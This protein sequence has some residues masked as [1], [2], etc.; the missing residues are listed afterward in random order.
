MNE[1]QFLLA[2]RNVVRLEDLAADVTKKVSPA[3]I[4]ALEDIAELI[5]NLPETSIGREIQYRQ[6]R[7][8]IASMFMGANGQFAAELPLAIR[9]EVENQMRFAF[10]YLEA[11]QVKTGVGT[12]PSAQAPVTV[13]ETARGLQ[14]S[15]GTIPPTLGPG[16]YQFGGGITRT[17]MLAVADDAQVLGVKLEKLFAAQDGGMSKWIKSNVDIIDRTIKTGF[18][19]GQT[20]EEVARAIVMKT[21]QTKAGVTALAR[22]GLMDMSQR[23]HNRFNDANRDRIAAYEY[24]AAF[25]YRVC[26]ICAPW[27]GVLKRKR[28]DFPDMI[29]HVNCRCALL[30]ITNTEWELRKNEA[31]RNSSFI[32]LVPAEK[33]VYEKGRVVKDKNGKVKMQK[34]PKPAEKNNEKFYARPVTVDGKKYWRKRVDSPAV[35]QSDQMAEFLYNSSDETKV[36]VMGVDRARTFKKL[37]REKDR[38]GNPRWLPQQALLQ[39]LPRRQ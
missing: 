36:E 28:S 31:P 1:R 38:N 14:P 12:V 29:R 33:P 27:S 37:M 32:D 8:R 11:A 30:P 4:R 5:K 17:Q 21:K 22:S 10:D 15:I 3:L 35:K 18:L 25:D 24:S 23:A 9:A 19:T 20:N 26:D 16:N 39:V 34:R 13:V 7:Q 6:M 2:T